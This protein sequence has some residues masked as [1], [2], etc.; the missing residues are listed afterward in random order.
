[1]TKNN[2]CLFISLAVSL[3]LII[4]GVVMFS[5]LGGFNDDGFTKDKTVITVTGDPIVTVREDFRNDLDEL[6]K[7]TLEDAGAKV[8]GGRYLE[9]TDK[10]TF[11]YT[12]N[13]SYDEATLETYVKALETAISTQKAGET[14]KTFGET[15]FIY[16]AQHRQNNLDYYKY[17]WTF[18]IAAAVVVVLAFAYFAIRFN[19]GMGIAMGIAGVHDVLLA[20]ALVALLRIPAGVGIA[21]IGAFALLFSVF[22]NGFVFGRMR[23]D[24]KSD[25]YKELPAREAVERSAKGSRK[26]VFVTAIIMLAVIVVLGVIGVVTGFD[27]TSFM[28]CA[29][30]AVLVNTYSSHVLSP[31]IFAVFKEKFDAAKAKKAKYNF[32]A[33]K[34]K[35]KE[36]VQTVGEAKSES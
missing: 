34:K 29:L 16:V 18:A 4:V 27:L 22:L 35:Q 17:M 19:L 2:K 26:P 36:K 20:L 1:M 5:V 23:R 9:T 30:V 32:D 13:G 33:E 7:T 25:E 15:S 3:V 24:F 10:G 11:E 8:G 6:C 12:L 28:L 14:D 31:S 21:A